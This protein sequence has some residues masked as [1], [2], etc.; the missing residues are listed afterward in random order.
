[1]EQSLCT[2]CGNSLRL[3]QSNQEIKQ[4]NQ[5]LIEQILEDT[6]TVENFLPID[7][8]SLTFS[9]QFKALSRANR[10]KLL[11]VIPQSNVIYYQT[12]KN[13]KCGE[14]RMLAPGTLIYKQERTIQQHIEEDYS[15]YRHSN[16]LPKTAKYI[17]PNT[18]CRTHQNPRL[19]N[20]AFL[21]IKNS[22]QLVYICMVC[23]NNWK[24]T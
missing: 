1:M 8:K 3:S 11:S 17:C 13:P 18:D 14:T 7:V 16:I 10:T 9:D 6:D 15:R 22:L 5:Q 19:R 20:A 4:D 12:C 23:D 21:R 24:H 2:I